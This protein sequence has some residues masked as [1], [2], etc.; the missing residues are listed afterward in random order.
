MSA[1]FQ[2]PPEAKAPDLLR[3]RAVADPSGG[4]ASITLAD[5]IEDASAGALQAFLEGRGDR[6]P[7]IMERPELAV[8]VTCQGAGPSP[9]PTLAFVGGPDRMLLQMPASST[10]FD[11]IVDII[12]RPSA[13]R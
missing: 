5:M 4:T 7:Q 11:V 10:G 2:R 12:F 3:Y 1:T 8:S 6:W 13:V 9:A